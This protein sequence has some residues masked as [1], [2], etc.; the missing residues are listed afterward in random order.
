MTM[1]FPRTRLAALTAI[2]VLAAATASAQIDFS[3]EWRSIPHEPGGD[4][5]IGD[6][7]G[8]PIND[9]AR[10][11][12]DAWD[13]SLLSLPELQCRPHPIPYAE[14]TPGNPANAMFRWW[15]DIDPITQQTIAYHKRGAW[16][17]PERTIWMDGR[18]HPPDY[19]PH[20][21]QGFSTGEWSG[22]VLKVTTTHIKEG[23]IRRN[24]VPVSDRT[25]T[26]EYFIRHG[27]YLTSN[28]YIDDPVYLGEPLLVTGTWVLDPRI[29]PQLQ[30]RY[31]CGPNEIVVE[32]LRPKGEV[33]H[34]LPG[35]NTMLREFAERYRLPFEAT[36]GGPETLYPEYMDRLKAMK[37]ATRDSS[38]R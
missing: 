33:P 9:D 16:M 8:L 21:W 1:T 30:Q 6:Y 13:A 23:F 25:T 22:S 2:L 35:Q 10:A 24:G 32:V 26:T 29:G 3:G 5:R 37:P 19:A 12:A 15:K 17:E 14:Q 7:T 18:P 28:L 34:H 36:R 31:P 4:P 38:A 20:T 11:V 27:N